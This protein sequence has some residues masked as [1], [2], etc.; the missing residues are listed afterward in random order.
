MVTPRVIKTWNEMNNLLRD[1]IHQQPAHSVVA[2][3]NGNPMSSF[4]E[5]IS[6]SQPSGTSPDNRNPLSRANLRRVWNDPAHFEALLK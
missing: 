3:V 4:V 6:S 1:T 5:L 2:I